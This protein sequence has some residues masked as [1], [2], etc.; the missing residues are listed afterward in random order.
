MTV[1]QD[2]CNSFLGKIIRQKNKYYDYNDSEPLYIYDSLPLCVFI[3][4]F[5]VVSTILET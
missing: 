3:D 5:E 4:K 1:S 2:Y